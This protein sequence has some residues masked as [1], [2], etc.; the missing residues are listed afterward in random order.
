MA[1]EGLVQTCPERIPIVICI[2]LDRPPPKEIA[3]VDSLFSELTRKW[4]SGMDEGSQS[5][6]GK[7]GSRSPSCIDLII[8]TGYALCP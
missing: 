8:H 2:C 1:L 3:I 6:E 4:D 5:W 7:E